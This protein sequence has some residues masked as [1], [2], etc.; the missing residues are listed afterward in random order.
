MKLPGAVSVVLLVFLVIPAVVSAAEIRGRFSA[1]QGSKIPA[2]ARIMVTCGDFKR[3][4][5][6]KPDGSYSIRGLPS[7]RGCTYQVEY[8][9]KAKS[10]LISFN[11]G[12]GVVRIN[13]KLR[14][15]G[16]TIIII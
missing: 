9:D 6:I 5:A 14:N 3:A 13:G 7:S 11:S 2:G 10:A 16:K 12:N 15:L 8:P 4:E 1:Y